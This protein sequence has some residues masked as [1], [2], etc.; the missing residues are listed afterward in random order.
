M[1]RKKISVVFSALLIAS[2][3]LTACSA[4]TPQVV[5]KVVTEVVKEEVKVVETSVVE[6]VVEPPVVSSPVPLA[7]IAWLPVSPIGASSSVDP[8]ETFLHRRRAL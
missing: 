3:V 8:L 5:K 2:M 7:G 6:K 4:P 1:S